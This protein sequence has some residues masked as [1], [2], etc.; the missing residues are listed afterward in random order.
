MSNRTSKMWAQF[1]REKWLLLLCLVLGFVAWQ[2]IRQIISYSQPMTDIPVIIQVP[3]EWA[4]LEKSVDTVDIDL[5]GAREDVR[6]ISHEPLR[7]EVPVKNPKPGEMI[8]LELHP[9]HL[10]N[11]PTDAKAIHFSPSVIEIMLDRRDSKRLPAKAAY[12]GELPENI[13]IEKVVCT[14]AFVTVNGAVQQL[15]SMEN[16][17]TEPIQLKNHTSTF[18]ENVRIALPQDGRLQVEPKRVSVE[19]ILAERSSTKTFENVPVRVLCN[20]DEKRRVNLQPLTVNITVHGGQQK[21]EALNPDELFA[22]ISCT[23]LTESTGYEMPVRINL[24]EGVRMIK[25]EPAA[26][27]VEIGNN[28]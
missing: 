7:V 18:K 20:P 11:N 14:P 19:F 12:E 1:R 23:E 3:D 8:R 15:N 25:S 13:E 26:V 24:P 2:A 16:I 21:I 17:Y 6:N 4:V 28:N 22:Y 9:R 5:Q 27:H 10:K